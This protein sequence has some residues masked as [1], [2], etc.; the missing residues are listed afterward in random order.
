MVRNVD[1]ELLTK[2]IKEM[3]IQANHY[4]APD[5]EKAMREACEKES[6]PLA[7]Q[8]LG[9]LLENLDI[10]YCGKGYDPYLPGYGNGSGI[11]ENRPGCPL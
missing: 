6:K 5:M 10:G 1:V 11:S 8:I 9:Q 3:C 4:L 2:N 7:K